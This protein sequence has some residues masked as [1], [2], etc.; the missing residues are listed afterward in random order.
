[1][2][3]WDEL[4]ELS[5]LEAGLGAQDATW[6]TVA[7][8]EERAGVSRSALRAWYRSGELPS[9]VVDGP[10]GPQRL[11]ALEAVEA[12]AR[13]SPRIARKQA[14]SVG[15]EAEVASL[16]DRVAALEQRLA[17]LESG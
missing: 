6:V 16:R 10:H 7:E 8:A 12:R 3:A 1:M 11:V 15:L 5:R 17:D 4:L 9:Q 2:D 14:R 13:R